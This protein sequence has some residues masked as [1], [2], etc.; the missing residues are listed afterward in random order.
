MIQA[1][2]MPSFITTQL[3]NIR[4]D[5]AI[6]IIFNRL[7]SGTYHMP[8]LVLKVLLVAASK[9]TMQSKRQ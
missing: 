8:C 3:H 2:T 7:I 1:Q 9:I 6:D 5:L 4:Q